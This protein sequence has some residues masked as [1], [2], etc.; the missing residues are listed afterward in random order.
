MDINRNVKKHAEE[1]FRRYPALQSEAEDFLYVYS[2]LENV[3]FNSGTLFLCGNGGSAADA[4]H[5]AGELL[6]GFRLRRELPEELKKR[7]DEAYPGEN[8]ADCLQMGL[9]AISLLSHPALSTAVVN[10]NHPLM[11]YAQTLFALG[12][13]GDAVLGISTSGKA[14]NVCNAFK[15]ARVMGIKTILLTGA[16]PGICAEYADAMIRVPSTVT[17]EIQE[18]HLPVYHALCSMLEERF[19]GKREE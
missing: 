12:N 11:S 3:F 13:P 16:Q 9:R 7:F 17:F 2:I 8:L 1:L 14:V 19:Y 4:E 10:D 5:I 6:K 15:T 18:Y